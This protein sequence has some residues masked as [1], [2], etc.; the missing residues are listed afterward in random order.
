MYGII[1]ISN[2]RNTPK[3]IYKYVHIVDSVDPTVAVPLCLAGGVLPLNRRTIETV[4]CLWGRGEKGGLFS[5]I[6]PNEQPATADVKHCGA[7]FRGIHCSSFSAFNLFD[8]PFPLR[9]PPGSGEVFRCLTTVALS[10]YLG[11]YIFRGC[12]DLLRS[13]QTTSSRVIRKTSFTLLYSIQ[14]LESTNS[15]S[16]S[17]RLE[18]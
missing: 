8:S 9:N 16:P 18:P 15:G 13:L 14:R 11:S 4:C 10:T 5:S 6:M 2:I 7:S 17:G 1:Y 3:Y 12:H